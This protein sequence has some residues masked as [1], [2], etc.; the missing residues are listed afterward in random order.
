MKSRK[1][2][3]ALLIII[4]LSSFAPGDW[5]DVQNKEGQFKM[6][7]PRQ[8]TESTQDIEEA[9]L[10]LK[11]HIFLYDASKYKDENMAY[12]I[13]YSDYPDTL[14][15]SDFKD[16]LLDTFFKNSIDGGAKNM[17]GTVVSVTKVN[18]KDFPG[19]LA[20]MSFMDGQGLC[21][22]KIF[23]VHSRI[24][25]LMTLCEPLKDKNPSMD[26]FFN[27]FVLLDDKK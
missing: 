24:Y 9:S 16:E 2:L 22:M 12:Y 18:Y 14:V 21:Y 17:N 27:S 26:K 6:K 23:L 8:P 10:P 3:L 7:F 1:P 19:R 13:M 15:N 25:I 11:M 4:L 5:V 20:K